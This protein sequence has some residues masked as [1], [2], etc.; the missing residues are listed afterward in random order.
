[1]NLTDIVGRV[2]G[3][4]RPLAVA[5]GLVLDR[6]FREPPNEIHPVALFGNAMTNVEEIVVNLFKLV[7]AV[8]RR[9]KLRR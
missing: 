7:K 2:T 3:A 5:S 8:Q 6:L 9:F 1:M 4:N